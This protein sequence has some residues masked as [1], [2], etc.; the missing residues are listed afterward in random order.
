MEIWNKIQGKKS[1]DGPHRARNLKTVT[2]GI[3]TRCRTHPHIRFEIRHFAD[4]PSNNF[5][6][7]CSFPRTY[8]HFLAR[9]YPLSFE[10]KSKIFL[11]KSPE[12]HLNISIA[13]HHDHGFFVIEMAPVGQEWQWGIRTAAGGMT[14]RRR[15]R[16]IIGRRT[17]TNTT[18]AAVVVV[19]LAS[20]TEITALNQ[21]QLSQ[22][23]MRA[24]P[25]ASRA[26]NID[27][28]LIHAGT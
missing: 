15:R 28:L 19:G 24:I 4:Q 26:T 9:V 16:R 7:I 1:A 25:K 8:S 3:K 23:L 27:L 11:R 14:G 2:V 22:I 20:P 21:E 13:E 17:S 12:P 18:V 5:F 6:P 10:A